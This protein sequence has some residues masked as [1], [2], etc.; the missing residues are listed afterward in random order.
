MEIWLRYDLRSP[1]FGTPTK[2]II[3]VALEQAAWADSRG[4]HTVQ[5]SEHH[6]YVDNYNPSPLVLGGAVA[7]VTSKLRINPPLILPLHDPIR[8]AEDCCVLDNISNGRL[9]ITAILGYMPGDFAMYG[10]S[11]GDRSRLAVRS[12]EVLAVAFSGRP[13][14]FEGRKGCVTPLPIQPGGPPIY[15]G[16]SVMATA[17]RAAKYGQG[18][19]PMNPDEKFVTEYRRACAELGKSPGKVL[20]YSPALFVHV[21]EDPDAAWAKIAPHAMHESNSYAKGAQA[22]GEMNPFP[23]A[24]NPEALRKTGAYLVL[25]PSQCLDYARRERQA[26]RF[27]TL[28]PM[29]GGLAPDLAWSSLELFG[30]EVL[31]TLLA[32]EKNESGIS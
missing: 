1:K 28:V 12:L 4:F 25:T 9:D 8:L 11:L 10:V 18:Y 5:L 2:T 26:G 31:P 24:E 22:T 14:D 6:G 23:A 16:G 30:N 3:S 32:E 17:R 29:M 19:Y 15:V 21:A 20:R 7:A 13:F 27:I